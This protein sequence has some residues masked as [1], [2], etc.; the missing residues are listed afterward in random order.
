MSFRSL[1]LLS[2]AAIACE[3]KVEASRGPAGDAAPDAI[4]VFLDPT[5]FANAGEVALNAC[6][7]RLRHFAAWRVSAL[8]AHFPPPQSSRVVVRLCG[9]C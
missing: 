9:V 4:Y 6:R 8:V 2:I 3:G 5:E 7:R 1:L